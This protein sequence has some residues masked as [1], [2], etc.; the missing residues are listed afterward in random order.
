[1]T[2][3]FKIKEIRTD[4]F[5]SILLTALFFIYLVYSGKSE[6]ICSKYDIYLSLSAT[7][8]G[9]LITAYAILITFPDS[10]KIRLLKKHEDFPTLFEAFILGIYILIA[11]FILSF[12]GFIFEI[13]GAFFCLIVLFTLV[14]SIIF[15]MRI[16]WILKKLTNIFHSS[17]EE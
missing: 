10:Y 9:F 16:V 11:L 2:S 4:F 15:V 13:S 3:L 5:I 14:Y 7:F 17:L 8:L 1:M 6:I 12:I